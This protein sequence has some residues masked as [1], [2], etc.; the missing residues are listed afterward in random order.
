MISLIWL[1]WISHQ[2]LILIVLLNFL[3]AIISQSYENVMSKQEIYKYQ[4][5]V[6]MNK[7]C[8][9]LLDFFGLLPDFN[10]LLIVT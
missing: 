5:R 8:L 1:M 3:I 6:Q 2:F 7:E 10:C 4:Q 9:Q